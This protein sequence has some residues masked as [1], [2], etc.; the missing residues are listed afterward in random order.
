MTWNNGT[1]IH[2]A[3]RF[4]CG[5]ECRVSS[6]IFQVAGQFA[7]EDDEE[8]LDSKQA[9]PSPTWHYVLPW[10]HSHTLSLWFSSEFGFPAF[11]ASGVASVNG[12][13]IRL[14]LWGVRGYVSTPCRVPFCF[15][16]ERGII[17]GRM[18]MA[19]GAGLRDD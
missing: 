6:I 8:S 4:G 19:L 15:V 18:W 16:R 10:K 17:S 7:F 11:I 14:R 3:F 1:R 13:A 9:V 5:R 12:R 2:L